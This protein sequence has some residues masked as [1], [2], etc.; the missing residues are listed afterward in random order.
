MGVQVN[1]VCVDP[2]RPTDQMVLGGVVQGPYT[3]Q[4]VAMYLVYTIQN[5]YFR[6]TVDVHERHHRV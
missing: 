1:N 5:I 3:M 6:K 2:L 4:E